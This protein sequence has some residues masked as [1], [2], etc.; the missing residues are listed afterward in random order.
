MSRPRN[1][2]GS[3]TSWNDLPLEVQEI[4]LHHY[5]HVGNT[6][7][8]RSASRVSHGFRQAFLPTSISSARSAAAIEYHR[9]LDW[10]K[11]TYRRVWTE[12][13][14][15]PAF[16]ACKDQTPG[17]FS[18]WH[19]QDLAFRSWRRDVSSSMRL[20]KDLE[21]QV[22]GLKRK[23]YLLSRLPELIEKIAQGRVVCRTS[24]SLTT[25]ADERAR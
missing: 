17:W 9:A 19:D 5:L 1:S 8:I 15:F 13:S 10:Q 2:R 20:L 24:S 25:V 4:I 22:D 11:T 6:D 16:A 12:Y 18:T 23:H 21:K 7:D 3:A 14:P